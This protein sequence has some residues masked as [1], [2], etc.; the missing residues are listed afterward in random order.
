[1]QARLKK[2]Y[3]KDFR[4]LDEFFLG[5]FHELWRF[6]LVGE[7]KV[8]LELVIL[9]ELLF[10]EQTREPRKKFSLHS[11]RGRSRGIRDI[12]MWITIRTYD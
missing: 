4:Y 2:K 8:E 9:Q 11:P 3:N 10:T 1:M 12:L 6:I 7:E 5:P